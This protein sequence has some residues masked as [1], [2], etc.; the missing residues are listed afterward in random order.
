MHNT[1]HL[2]HYLG[3]I[4]VPGQSTA[5]SDTQAYDLRGK[6]F[7]GLNHNYRRKA[8]KWNTSNEA[9]SADDYGFSLSPIQ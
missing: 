8:F 3:G 5:D 2:L 6:G 4:R 7:T 9:A 1:V